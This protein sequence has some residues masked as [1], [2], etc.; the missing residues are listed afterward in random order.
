M[1]GYLNLQAPL[2]P[3]YGIIWNYSTLKMP[4]NSKGH[5]FKD[6]NNSRMLYIYMCVEMH[7]NLCNFLHGDF[8]KKFIIVEER[9]QSYWVQMDSYDFVK[10]SI[11]AISLRMNLSAVFIWVFLFL[12]W[13]FEWCYHK[14]L[15]VLHNTSPLFPV[16]QK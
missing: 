1:F 14:I 3:A 2:I 11:V 15:L 7:S 9:H 13:T 4:K 6:R 10:R 5:L 16:I 8:L 12:N